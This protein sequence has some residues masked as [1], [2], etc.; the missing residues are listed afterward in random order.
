MFATYLERWR[1]L[2]DGEAII[3]P[4][5]RLLPV[6]L[7]DGAPAMLKL[8]LDEDEQGGNRLMA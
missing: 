3:T 2:P 8:A 6:R 1:L 7:E 5:S 4:G